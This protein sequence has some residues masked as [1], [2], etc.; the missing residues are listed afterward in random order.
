MFLVCSRNIARPRSDVQRLALLWSPHMWLS[1]VRRL[2]SC[3]LID[4]T[5]TV[6]RP[7]NPW[8]CH[9]YIAECHFY[10]ALTTSRRIIDVLENFSSMGEVKVVG[11]VYGLLVVDL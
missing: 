8:E 2:N 5:A 10:L 1:H 3:L 11:H 9:L 4:H 6:P 7:Q